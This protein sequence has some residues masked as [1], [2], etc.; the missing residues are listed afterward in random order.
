[1]KTANETER[2]E[3]RLAP[4]WAQGENEDGFYDYQ[5]GW[6]IE[7]R[8]PTRS[9]D[10]IFTNQQKTFGLDETGKAENFIESL[11]GNPSNGFWCT[12][13]ENSADWLLTGTSY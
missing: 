10:A 7:A 6:V 13:D 1:M 4:H 2:A 3:L 12:I 8:L 9:G 11:C 5:K